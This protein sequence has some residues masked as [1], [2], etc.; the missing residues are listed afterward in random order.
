MFFRKKYAFL[1]NMYM[2]PFTLDGINFKTVEHFYQSQKTENIYEKALIINA[3]NPVAAKAFGKKCHLVDYWTIEY[4]LTVMRLAIKYKFRNNDSLKKKLLAIKEP[5]IEDNDWND[6]FWGMHN[7]YGLNYLGKLLEEYK[8]RLEIRIKNYKLSQ[9]RATFKFNNG[10]GALLC[11]NCKVIIKE[12]KDYNEIEE[13]A[14]SNNYFLPK[15]YCKKCKGENN[16]E[17]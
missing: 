8:T 12:G 6:T 5:I 4:R 16:D 10:R 14:L 1:S 13:K 15:Q 3:N 2:S 11:D 17:S 9:E 7:G